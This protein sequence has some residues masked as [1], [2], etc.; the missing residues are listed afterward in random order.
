MSEIPAS[1][2][3]SATVTT[4]STSIEV[5]V[6]MS[7]TGF[8]ATLMGGEEPLD[9]DHVTVTAIECDGHASVTVQVRGTNPWGMRQSGTYEAPTPAGRDPHDPY[10]SRVG[11]VQD[12]PAALR[13]VIE[14]ACGVVFA[15]Y[16]VTT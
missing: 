5:F 4:R 1:G 12:L 10:N 8:D 16:G 6:S 9:V 3:Q 2:P 14:D 7:L 13:T 15:D 11:H